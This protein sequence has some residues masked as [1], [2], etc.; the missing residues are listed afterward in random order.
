MSD[1]GLTLEQYQQ[2]QDMQRRQQMGAALMSGN[3][4]AA[5]AFGGLANMG[6]ALLGAQMA[7]NANTDQSNM[8]NRMRYAAAPD[9]S[10]AM[11]QAQGANGK[12]FDLGNISTKTPL[13]QSKYGGPLANLFNLG[14]G[15]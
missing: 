2:L 5:G 3:A 9:S 8:L 11:G 6:S 15:S 13:I 12:N 10:V 7:N 14:G 1:P 4:G